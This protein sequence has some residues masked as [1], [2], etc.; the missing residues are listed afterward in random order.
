M[1]VAFVHRP[2]QPWS[3]ILLVLAI[4]AAVLVDSVVMP[5]PWRGMEHRFLLAVRWPAAVM[6]AMLLAAG[7]AGLVLRSMSTARPAV[8]DAEEPRFGPPRLAPQRSVRVVTVVGLEAGCGATTLAFNLATTLAVMGERQGPDSAPSPVQS[9]C[10]LSENA[11]SAAL[12]VSSEE[13]EGALSERPWDVRQEIV[14]LGVRHPS[15]CTIFCLKGGR[16]DDDV[17][18]LVEQLARHYDV[19]II[20]G[21]VSS[22]ARLSPRDPTDVLLLVGLPSEASIDAAGSWV[23]RVWHTRRET[24][25]VM[26]V[27]RAPAWPPPPAEL[28][29]AFHHLVLIPNEMRVAMCDRQGLPWSLDD[30]LAATAQLTATASLLFPGLTG[31][32]SAHAA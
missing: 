1:P 9:A 26:V 25:T 17:M 18:R 15:G 5:Q 7:L 28:V 24:S 4:A 30:R 12:G 29:L 21:A 6:L 13:L 16:T 23:E 22:P 27:N 11:L 31:G 2:P 10:L 20:D 8:A 14:E 32:G 19:L 3:R